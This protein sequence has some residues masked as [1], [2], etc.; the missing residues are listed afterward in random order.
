MSLQE[1]NIGPAVHSF[2]GPAISLQTALALIRSLLLFLCPELFYTTLRNL[3]PQG[4]AD[5]VFLN[6]PRAQEE[7]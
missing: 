2:P 5:E 3:S 4:R 6:S 1:L 7:S